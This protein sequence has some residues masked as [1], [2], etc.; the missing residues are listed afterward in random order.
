MGGNVASG[1][2]TI[3]GATIDPAIENVA[4]ESDQIGNLQ[5]SPSCDIVFPNVVRREDWIK[6]ECMRH[7]NNTGVNGFPEGTEIDLGDVGR[8][9]IEVGGTDGMHFRFVVVV[10]DHGSE[11]F[12]IVPCD[13]NNFTDKFEGT[14]QNPKVPVKDNLPFFLFNKSEKVVNKMFR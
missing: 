9:R 7:W 8:P 3:V 2:T 13:V 6:F 10:L 11:N 12:P 5:V 1:D 4:P 14:F